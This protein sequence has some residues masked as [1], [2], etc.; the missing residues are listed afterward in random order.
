MPGF[1]WVVSPAAL[2][3]DSQR[4]FKFDTYVLCEITGFKSK[5]AS[6]FQGGVE[7]ST[8]E[9]VDIPFLSSP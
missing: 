9:S 3:N 1:E 6:D 2:S 5:V 7:Y 8:D 4:N